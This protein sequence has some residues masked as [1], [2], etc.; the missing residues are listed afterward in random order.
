[1]EPIGS[2]DWTGN[3]VNPVL[4]HAG[5][6]TEAGLSR[7]GELLSTGRFRLHYAIAASNAVLL[8]VD[9]RRAPWQ[10]SHTLRSYAGISS[11]A[12]TLS[13]AIFGCSGTKRLV[14]Q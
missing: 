2:L 4:H 12:G 11:P 7:R 5:R 6:Y 3:G 9:F 8:S 13:S 14:L 10:R 1:M